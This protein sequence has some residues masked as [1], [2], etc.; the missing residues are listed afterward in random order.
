MSVWHPMSGYDPQARRT[1]M[2]S[3]EGCWVTDDTGR[4]YL[5]AKSGLWCVN[6]GY[7]RDE[8]ADAARDQLRTLPY[9]PLTD[10]HLP[11]QRLAARLGEWLGEDYVF[12]FSNSG[13]EAN[14]VAFKIAR[15]YHQQCGEPYR[16]KIV[17]SYRAYHGQTPG[18][19]AATGQNQRK[20]G[21]EPLPAGF[22]HVAPPDPYRCHLCEGGCTLRCAGEVERVLRFELPETVAAVIAEPVISGG[23]VIV[24]PA[25]YLAAVAAICARS[26]ALLIVD[27]AVCGFGRTGRRFGHQH[28][29]IV[30][31]IVT[32]AKAVA[33]GYF[34]IAVTAV[35]REIHERFAATGQ[36]RLRHIN[37]FGGHPAACAVA[38]R[39]MDIMDG[40]DLPARAA[41]N[42]LARRLK[43]LLALPQVGE[44]RGL[45]LLAGVE[46][47]EDRVSRRP[48]AADVTRRVVAACRE[49]GVV[50]GMNANTAAGLSNVVMAGPPLVAGEEELDLLTTTL[51]EAIREVL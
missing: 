46:L 33:N 48:V 19:L 10:S 35:R 5:D 9:Y 16:Q 6:A 50:V 3:G 47:V 40:E 38:L 43:P 12:F 49:R 1:V 29:G 37:T 30:P 24:P 31:D 20:L 17:S 15:Q 34:P 39:T 41:G 23:G 2:V 4:R 21:Y 32:M 13:S 36:G 28:S 42:A 14:E 22:L 11:A 45:G 44:V 51:E 18:A 27:E 7:G 25:G 26:G 8:L